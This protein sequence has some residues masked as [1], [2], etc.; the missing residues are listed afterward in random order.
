MTNPAR[1][2][3]NSPEPGKVPATNRTAERE[4]VDPPAPLVW[5]VLL[6]ALPFLVLGALLGLDA[7][8]TGG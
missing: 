2:T 7:C 3:S 4:V 8:R 6:A 1:D 5:R